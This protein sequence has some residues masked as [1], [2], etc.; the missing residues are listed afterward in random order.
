MTWQALDTLPSSSARLSNPV[1]CLMILLSVCSMVV[2]SFCWLDVHHQQIARNIYHSIN[3][4]NPSE[5]TLHLTIY[6]C[7]D[8]FVEVL[9]NRANQK[10]NNNGTSRCDISDMIWKIEQEQLYKNKTR[11]E[12]I[13][14][15]QGSWANSNPYLTQEEEQ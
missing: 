10:A 14:T 2:L 5:D 3:S 7:G 6:E 12:L 13:L 15:N 11:H 4:G 8:E 1:L 9:K